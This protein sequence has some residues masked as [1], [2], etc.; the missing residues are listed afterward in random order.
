[1]NLRD[2]ATQPVHH[3]VSQLVYAASRALV[4]DVWIAGHEVLTDGQPTLIDPIET[5]ARA[6]TWRQRLAA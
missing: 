3:V 2:A 4:T 1:M 6:D 5:L